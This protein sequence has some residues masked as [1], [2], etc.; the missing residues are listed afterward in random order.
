MF[1][2]AQIDTES[3]GKR[4]CR[5]FHRYQLQRLRRISPSEVMVI[6]EI[7]K[8]H[9]Q[10]S[11]V[12]KFHENEL[13]LKDLEQKKIEDLK[14]KKQKEI[15]NQKIK[16]WEDKFDQELKLKN[17]KEAFKFEQ[18]KIKQRKESKNQNLEDKFDQRLK[19]K[20]EKEEL[21]KKE[22]LISKLGSFDVDNNKK[23]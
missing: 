4:I 20:N 14:E 19:L 1:P 5:A 6:L 18:L 10:S 16:Q 15:E 7:Y 23:N 2:D 21:E 11:K 8:I 3:D 9:R 22:D 17:E 13:K 12:I